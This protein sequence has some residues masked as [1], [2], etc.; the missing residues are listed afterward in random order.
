ME[1]VVFEMPKKS[2]P[3]KDIESVIKEKEDNQWIE[4]A[5]AQSLLELAAKR[6]DITFDT[7]SLEAPPNQRYM[8]RHNDFDNKKIRRPGS[9]VDKDGNRNAMLVL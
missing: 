3:M 4:K 7:D 6:T 1:R 5:R 8:L 9:H 2:K